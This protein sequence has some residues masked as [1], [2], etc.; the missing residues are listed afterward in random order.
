MDDDST[1][2]GEC[3]Y[4][5][6]WRPLKRFFPDPNDDDFEIEGRTPW[7]LWKK[8]AIE[9]GVPEDLTQL[10]SQVI[11]EAHHQQWAQELQAECG[12]DDDGELMVWSALNI[13]EKCR[14]R[15]QYLLDS[16]GDFCWDDPSPKLSGYDDIP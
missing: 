10:G 14:I 3:R 11:R 1:G 6:K 4:V 8:W 15:W 13:P 5:S 9:D 2:Q 7:D 12:W 16:R